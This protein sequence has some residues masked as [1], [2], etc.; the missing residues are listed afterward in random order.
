MSKLP[1][2]AVF[3]F[4]G[5]LTRR[6]SLL[7]FLRF[8][9]GQWQF[10]WGLFIMTPML[11]GYGLKLIPN[12]RA[13]EA[14]LT[15][16]I[17]G[18]TEEKLQ[19]LGQR[20]AVQKIP[21]LLCNEALQRLCWHQDRGHPTFLVSASVEAYLLPWAKTMGFEQAI[22]TQLEIQ[23]NRLT[24]RIL[25]KNCYG[26]EKVKRLRAKLGDLNKYC[27]Y[28]YGDSRGDRELLEVANYPFYRTF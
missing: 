15:Y 14:I 16:F 6:D 8:A 4:D 18:W 2:V 24:G 21:K 10:W 20:F 26:K 5:T 7:P 12:W 23:N 22:C 13:K 1:V 11:A 28:V 25:G 3:D 17:G 9:V 27:I 19:S